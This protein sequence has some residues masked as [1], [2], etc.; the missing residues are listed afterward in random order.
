MSRHDLLN[1]L[2]CPVC[3]A[4]ALHADDDGARCR[5]CGRMFP[6]RGGILDLHPDPTESARQ[7]IAAHVTLGE[8][9]LET[10]VP[11]HLRPLYAGETGR[12]IALA[13]PRC[14][15]KELVDALESV[16]RIDEIAEDYFELLDR[17]RFN[18]TETVVEIG[19]HLGWCARHLSERAGHVIAT[20]ISPGLEM[21]GMYLDL[22]FRFDRVFCD[23]MVF[24]FRP[25]TLD[26]V[27]SVATIHHTDDLTG[28]FKRVQ[29][30]LKPGA[31]GVFFSEPVAGRWDR[32]VL[33]EFGAKERELGAQEHIYTISQY[34]GAARAAGLRPS[35][36]PLSGL[37]R[38]QSRN[39]PR[40]RGAALRFLQSG[41]GYSKAATTLLYP[42][43]LQFYPKV[44]FPRF[45]LVLRKPV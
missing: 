25:E 35:V 45:A 42:L 17:L 14:P 43:L 23:M 29:R 12:E 26:M 19:A 4:P 9:W 32:Q 33:A 20:D 6:L 34:F 18:G 36:L 13:A 39:W 38:D 22:G 7:E 21:A 1:L 30:A 5:A 16:R 11:E 2:E 40:L 27:F 10:Q 37:C 24:P 8:N 3:A 28:L 31:R 15:F 41:M 44:P